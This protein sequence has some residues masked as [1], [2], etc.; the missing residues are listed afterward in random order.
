MLVKQMQ[1]QVGDEVEFQFAGRTM[2]GEVFIADFMGSLENEYHSYDVLANDDGQECLY[3]H[4]P[5]ANVTKLI[6]PGVRKPFDGKRLDWR[7][8]DG[9]YQIK[10]ASG[11]TYML[12][13]EQR[14]AKLSRV[15]DDHQLRKD[16]TEL[17]VLNFTVLEGRT[18]VLVLEPL[19]EGPVTTRLTSNVTAIE[20]V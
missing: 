20:K 2:Q 19:G 17:A 3:K 16:G 6:K 12:K 13:L 8:E 5:E 14:T 18:A 9:T 10:T 1:Y 7:T 11:S 15:N 4:I